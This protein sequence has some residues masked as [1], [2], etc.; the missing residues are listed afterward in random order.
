MEVVEEVKQEVQEVKQE[1]QVATENA[2]A[3]AVKETAK[4]RI[5]VTD[6][7]KLGL[8]RL[9]NEFLKAQMEM[10]R[11]QDLIKNVQEVYPK[12]VE[13]LQKKYSIDPATHVYDA[14]QGAFVKKN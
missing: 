11:L 14:I 6:A 7:E 3:E 4:A 5:E 2:I 8:V 9:E 1:A 12:Q 10:R 13:Q